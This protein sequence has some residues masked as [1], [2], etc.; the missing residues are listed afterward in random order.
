MNVSHARIVASA[1]VSVILETLGGVELSSKGENTPLREVKHAIVW[2]HRRKPEVNV[3]HARIVASAIVSVILETLGRA[4]S[5]V[6]RQVKKDYSSHWTPHRGFS[7]ILGSLIQHAT[8]LR[9][10]RQ[11]EVSCFP[12]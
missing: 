11:L 7:G 12:F 10:R 2:S 6:S 5:V 9:R 3:S 1:I 8:F 4:D